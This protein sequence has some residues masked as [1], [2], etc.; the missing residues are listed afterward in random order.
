VNVTPQ[1]DIL[2]ADTGNNRLVFLN[3]M[4]HLTGE[5]GLRGNEDGEFLEP[6]SVASDPAGNVVWVA[7]TGNNRVQVFRVIRT[8][9]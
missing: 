4:Y 3:R 8:T 7:D 1:G 5:H 6:C 2:I 9:E